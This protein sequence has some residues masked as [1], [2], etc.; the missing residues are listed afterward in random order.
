MG[1]IINYKFTAKDLGLHFKV[2]RELANIV[3][4]KLML[5]I[6]ASFERY[7]EEYV[8]FLSGTLAQTTRVMPD[9]V[10]Y[11][12]PYAHYQYVLHDMAADLAGTTNRTRIY[13]PKATSWWDQAMMTEKGKAFLKEVKRLIKMRAREIYG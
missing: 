11:R 6:H 8:P 3:D 2:K 10:E 4:D 9:Y 1:A 5:R 12:A 13:H 7:C